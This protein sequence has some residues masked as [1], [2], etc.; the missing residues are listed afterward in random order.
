MSTP[1]PAPSPDGLCAE[2]DEPRRF[3]T[4]HSRY[5]VLGFFGADGEL[6]ET[7]QSRA[8]A[9]RIARAHLGPKGYERVEVYDNMARRGDPELWAVTKADTTV[10]ERRK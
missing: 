4:V 7:A 1:N 2:D 10:L 6:A 8:E 3:T 9:F 5:H